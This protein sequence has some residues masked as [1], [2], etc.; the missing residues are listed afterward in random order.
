MHRKIFALGYNVHNTAD[1]VALP[2]VSPMDKCHLFRSALSSGNVNSLVLLSTC[3]R[4]EVYGEGN[5]ETALE[6]FKSNFER[7]RE[8][9]PFC[10]TG[11]EAVTY[12]CQVASGA[13]SQLLG[14]LEILGQFKRAVAEAKATGALSG[15]FEKLVNQAVKAAKKVRSQTKLS[16]GTTSLAYALIE[17]LRGQNL[18]NH[19][20]L[21]VGTGSFG[22]SVA[23][24]LRDYTPNNQVSLSNRTKSTAENLALEIG[25]DTVDFNDVSTHWKYFDVVIT[26]LGTTEGYAIQYLTT[27]FKKTLVNLSVQESIDPKLKEH[28][29]WVSNADLAAITNK[30][31]QER[32]KDLPIVE[33][34]IEEEVSEFISWSST[35]KKMESA[36]VLKEVLKNKADQC[37]VLNSLGSS[38]VDPYINKAI[39]KY[40]KFIRTHE[41]LDLGNKSLLKAFIDSEHNECKEVFDELYAFTLKNPASDAH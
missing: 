36:R 21:L 8:S 3:N 28:H 2:S 24:N 29:Q 9:P 41:N 16:D 4:V 34:L 33:A 26:T 23:Y 12:I 39:G 13:N 6:H 27:P 18:L 14:D 30:T 25:A 31:H 22:K 11:Q 5:P 37:P 32:Q 38:I 10:L 15:Y 1:G 40:A 7:G 19:K 20:I 17:Y 35:Y